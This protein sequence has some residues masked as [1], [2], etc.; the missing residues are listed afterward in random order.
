M[1]SVSLL[2]C[3]ILL[4]LFLFHFLTKSVLRVYCTNKV[5]Y[6]EASGRPKSR[7]NGS[8]SMCLQAG[9]WT[10]ALLAFMET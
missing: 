9:V 3:F 10:S 6:V 8:S 5:V 1:C 4:L 2:S 7:K